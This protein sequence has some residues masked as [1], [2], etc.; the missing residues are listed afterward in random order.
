MPARNAALPGYLTLACIVFVFCACI[1]VLVYSW[2]DRDIFMSES[3]PGAAVLYFRYAVALFGLIT[4]ASVLARLYRSRGSM[5][6]RIQNWLPIRLLIYFGLLAIA[7]TTIASQAVLFD[8][9]RWLR[10]R[11]FEDVLLAGLA[12]WTILVFGRRP[13]FSQSLVGFWRFVDI[14][15]ANIAIVLFVSEI[16]VSMWASSTLSQLTVDS[17]SSQSI[18]DKRR[19]SAGSRRFDFPANSGGY[20]DKEFF[21][22]TEND[23]VVALLADSFGVGMVPYD[24]NFATVAERHLQEKLGT[25]FERV[26]IHNFGVPGA[27]MPEYI[28]L[29]DHEVLGFNPSRIVFSIFVGNDIGGM[30][31]GRRQRQSLDD[32]WTWTLAKRILA[33]WWLKINRGET[34]KIG[35]PVHSSGGLPEHLDEPSKERPSF[36]ENVFLTIESR[37]FNILNARSRATENRFQAFFEALDLLHSRLGEQLLVVLIPDE[38]QVNDDLYKQVLA[39]QDNPEVYDRD[40]P[41]RRILD[42][43]NRKGIKV[44]DLLPNLREAEKESRTYH[45]RDS[46]WNANGNRVA[47]KLIAEALLQ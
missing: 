3:G 31:H 36:P 27:G 13:V 20:Y 21:R 7:T 33:L 6:A 28:Y 24:Y 5:L 41:Q 45:L 46:H 29:L 40:L 42:F 9:N 37:R 38:F 26:A 11:F 22:A 1:I 17:Y 43:A 32:W 25:K 44:L 34:D 18:L 10:A 39:I 4:S 19:R 47:G 30:A 35:V 14:S 2:L 23:F 8:E 15:L 16:S 12:L